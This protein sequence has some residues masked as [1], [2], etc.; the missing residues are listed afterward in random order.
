M[1]NFELSNAQI[2]HGLRI[3]FPAHLCRCSSWVTALCVWRMWSRV[4]L[5]HICVKFLLKSRPTLLNVVTRMHAHTLHVGMCPNGEDL[6]SFKDLFGIL[7][8]AF[9]MICVLWI[10]LLL[11][12][13]GEARISCLRC[14]DRFWRGIHLHYLC[15]LFPLWWLLDRPARCEVLGCLQVRVELIWSIIILKKMRRH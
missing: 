1:P 9:K 7:F 12:Q 6:V 8:V 3:I 10:A 2:S 15:C 13:E 5:P 11:L 14:H 4:C